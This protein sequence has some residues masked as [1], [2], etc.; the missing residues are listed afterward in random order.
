MYK[1]NPVDTTAV[2]LP[3]DILLLA[4]EMAQNTHDLW[5]SKRIQE[6]WRYGALRSDAERTHPGIV[7]YSELTETEKDYDRQ[8]ALETLRL[9]MK[10]GYQIVPAQEGAPRGGIPKA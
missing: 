4:E 6:G 3:P 8:T 7:P 2:I 5:A 9:V 1:P 10:F